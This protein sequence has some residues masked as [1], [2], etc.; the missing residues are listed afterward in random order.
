[1]PDFGENEPDFGDE[2]VPDFGEE[3]P[4]FADGK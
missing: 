4:D 2:E 1:V 3:E